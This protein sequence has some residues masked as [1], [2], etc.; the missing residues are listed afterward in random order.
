MKFRYAKDLDFNRSLITAYINNI[1]I[2]SKNLTEANADNDSVSFSIPKDVTQSNNYNVRIEFNLAIN[3]KECTARDDKNPWAF[4]SNGSYVS[5]PT[6]NR[7]II[8]LII[9]RIHL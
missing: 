2:G 4:I 5:L 6:S 7:I 1:P 8:V 9:I 3:A